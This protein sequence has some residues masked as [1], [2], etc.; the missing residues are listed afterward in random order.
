MSTE[1]LY[2]AD[3]YAREA[4]ATV[5]SAAPEVQRART[6]AR[7][8]MTAAKFDAILAR[9]LPDADKRA[10]ATYVIAT[11]VPLERTRA[12]VRHVI[13]CMAPRAG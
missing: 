2:R 7:P 4:E 3:P 12:A 1:L 9:Q 13:A 11:D 8:G 10:R 5:V 6:L